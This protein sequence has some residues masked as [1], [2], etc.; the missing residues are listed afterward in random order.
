M[1]GFEPTPAAQGGPLARGLRDCD[2]VW[3]GPKELP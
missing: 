1:K 2:V 3:F